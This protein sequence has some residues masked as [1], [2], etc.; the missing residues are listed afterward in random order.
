MATSI[1]FWS[2]IC[3]DRQCHPLD[4]MRHIAVGRRKISGRFQLRA[5]GSANEPPSPIH[6][7]LK[8]TAAFML[9]RQR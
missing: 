1:G 5:T 8:Y 2:G 4:P 6:S 9:K 3:L 7:P